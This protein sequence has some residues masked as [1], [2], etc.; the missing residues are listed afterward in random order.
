MVR[1]GVVVLGCSGGGAGV[2][3][4]GRLLVV[5]GGVVVEVP[6]VV[7]GAVVPGTGDVVGGGV[8]PP[9]SAGSSGAVIA[10]V[11]SLSARRIGSCPPSSVV[12]PAVTAPTSTATSPGTREERRARCP[13]TARDRT[14][15][16]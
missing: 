10:L 5:V 6:P 7:V 4:D 9:T 11:E 1:R 2:D 12:A 16:E 14:T 13:A 15:I 3:S 8:V